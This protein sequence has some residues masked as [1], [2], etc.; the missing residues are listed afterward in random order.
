MLHL[1]LIHPPYSTNDAELLLLGVEINSTLVSTVVLAAGG[2][3]I[4]LLYAQLSG[5]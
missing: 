2:S 4:N 3:L 5:T 1:F